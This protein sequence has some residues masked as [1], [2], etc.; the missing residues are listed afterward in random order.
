MKIILNGTEVEAEPGITVRSF[1]D[2]HDFKGKNLILEWNG[3]IL[4]LGKAGEAVLQNGDS[5]NVFSLV[6]GG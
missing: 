6:G 4:P 5:L 1:L 2:A 3:E